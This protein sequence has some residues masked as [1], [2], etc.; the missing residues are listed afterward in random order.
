MIHCS[1]RMDFMQICTMPSTHR[2][3]SAVFHL[4]G[5]S[6]EDNPVY[7]VIYEKVGYNLVS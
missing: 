2:I 7:I 5:A 6:W 4:Y 3:W 1:G